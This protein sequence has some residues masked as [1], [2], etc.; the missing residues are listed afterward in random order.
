M[1][2]AGSSRWDQKVAQPS[3]ASN[4][5]HLETQSQFSVTESGMTSMID[6][7]QNNK[8]AAF[9][10]ERN[11]PLTDE[12]LDKILPSVGYEVSCTNEYFHFSSLLFLKQT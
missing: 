6:T 1:M 9:F 11:R 4:N 3:G 2:R 7:T 5:N 12:E 10:D 8:Q